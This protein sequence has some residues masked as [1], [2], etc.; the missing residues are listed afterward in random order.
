M[1]RIETLAIGDELLTGKTSDTNSSYV[2]GQLFARGARLEKTQTVL[3][4]ENEIL[5]ALVEAT[6]RC[7]FLICFGGLG[8]TSDDKTAEIIAKRL[9]TKVVEH[10]ASREQLEAFAKKRNRVL[11]PALL[12]QVLYPQGTD[13]LFNTVGL[14]PGFACRLGRARCFF[15]P[16]VPAEMKAMFAAGV[17]PEIERALEQS[18]LPKLFTH[19]WKCIGIPE[20][21]LQRAM[22]PVEAALPPEAW[23]GYRTRYPENHLTLY[24]KSL[25]QPA[26]WAA[27]LKDISKRIAAY[28]Y[29]D[30]QEELET[31][32]LEGL[33]EKGWRLALAESCTGGLVAQRLTAIAGSSDVFWGSAVVYQ[34]AAKKGLLGV[35]LKDPLDAVSAACSRQLAEQL[36]AHSGAEVCAAIT[37]YMGPAGGTEADPVGTSYLCVLSPQGV[38]ERRIAHPSPGRLSNQSGAATYLLHLILETLSR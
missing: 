4:D 24:W 34:V 11:T 10:P 2:A 12:K 1:L 5:A 17:L 36:K 37:G 29:T 30:S 15:L 20:S 7:D 38:F 18:G 27:R 35:D 8:P 14:A 26:D 3:D 28:T 16:G 22:D 25:A 19:G 32:V 9:S 6:Q 23:L 13:A 21:E 33:R 31:L